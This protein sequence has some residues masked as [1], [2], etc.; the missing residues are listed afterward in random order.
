MPDILSPKARELIDRPVLASLTTL[1]ADGSPQVTPIWVDLDGDDLLFN[2]A[3]GRVKARNLHRDPR[4]AVSVIDP[5]DPYNVVALRG[6]VAD[7]TTDGADAHIDS[8]AKK[9]L[10]VD[11]YPMRSE[12]EVRIKVRVRTDHIAMQGG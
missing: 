8:L 2:T 6:S 1:N 10:G 12:G 11:T 4:V 9:Y 5:E 7:I 3:E